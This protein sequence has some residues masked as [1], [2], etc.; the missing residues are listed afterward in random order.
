MDHR[1]RMFTTM[2]CLVTA[3]TGT[4]VLLGWMA[5]SP[6]N[7]G[8]RPD[9]QYLNEITQ[10]A[11]AVVSDDVAVVDDRWH[12]IYVV[13]D[14]TADPGGR[15]LAAQADTVPWHFFVDRDGHPAR[16]PSWYEQRAPADSPNTVHIQ[17]APARQ[18]TA[19]AL[20][21][22]LGVRALVA[23]LNEAIPAERAPLPVTLPQTWRSLPRAGSGKSAG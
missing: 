14:A 4:S 13:T 20:L 5:P 17:V 9:A 22:R 18:G 1:K 16:A 11:Y 6:T 10:L 21:Q 15:L 3:M 23:A 19:Q 7:G 8:D 2:A 12:K